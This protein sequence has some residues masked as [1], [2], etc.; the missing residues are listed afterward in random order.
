MIFRK[1]NGGWTHLCKKNK[2]SCRREW[3]PNSSAQGEQE[4]QKKKNGVWTPLVH[5]EDKKD[6]NEPQNETTIFSPIR[7]I[8]N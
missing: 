6:L 4:K 8:V 3:R 7:W 1:Q 2:K 5:K